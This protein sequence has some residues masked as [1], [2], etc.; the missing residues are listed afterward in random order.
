[1]NNLILDAEQIRREQVTFIAKVYAWMCGALALTAVTA[2]ITAS[3]PAILELIFGN[4]I[5]FYG[6]IIAEL[7]LV[8]Y[9]SSAI[10]RMSAAAAIFRMI[11]MDDY[12]VICL[13]EDR[14]NG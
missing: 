3:S 13:F 8:W 12:D 2:L 1:M 14:V 10:Q 9:L 7:G 4:K 6:L 11:F 5:L